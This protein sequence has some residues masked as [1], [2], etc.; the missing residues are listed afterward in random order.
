[1]RFQDFFGG[2]ILRAE[3]V[4]EAKECREDVPQLDAVDEGIVTGAEFQFCVATVGDRAVDV[5]QR[6]RDLIETGAELRLALLVEAIAFGADVIATGLE[7]D[8]IL[9]SQIQVAILRRRTFDGAQPVGERLTARRC[10]PMAVRLQC[11]CF[12]SFSR[13]SVAATK[14]FIV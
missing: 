5:L 4:W 9:L 7:L 10:S 2:R 6:A 3:N 12:S 8:E 11:V 13:S 14:S 1:M